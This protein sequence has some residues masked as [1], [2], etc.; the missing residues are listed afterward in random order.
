MKTILADLGG[1]HLRL[2]DAAA[3]DIIKKYKIFDYPD[4]ETVLKE[5]SPEISV[6]YMATAIHPRQGVIEDKRFE[7]KSHWTINLADLKTELGLEKI[8]IFNDLEAATYSLS[9]LR[10]EQL[11]VFVRATE[12]SPHFESPP[13]LLVGVGTGI[14]HAYL[15]EKPNALPL[16][17]RSHGGHIPPIA[18]SNEQKDIVKEVERTKSDGRDVIVEDIVSGTGIQR[19]E[20]I[21][22]TQDA[23]RLFWEFLGI[24]CNSLVS[25]CGAYGGV[26]L[27]GGV[28]DELFEAGKYEEEAFKKYFIPRLVPVVV[29]SLSSTPVY[30][31]KER[32]MPILGLHN[33][34]GR[35]YDS[36]EV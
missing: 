24:Y 22:G 1:T 10:G 27:T 26:Y 31:C 6:L 2:A 21:A 17:Q 3:P 28:M 19:L 11:G 16:V 33:L 15:F 14:G 23:L 5:F 32:N 12:N 7:E 4:I 20:E 9:Q 25:A 18:I 36:V 13:R 34:I 8:K 29:E 35:K 30:Y